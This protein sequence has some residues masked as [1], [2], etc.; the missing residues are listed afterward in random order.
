MINTFVRVGK[1]QQCYNEEESHFGLWCIMS[2]PLVLGFNMSNQ[3][4]MGRVWPVTTMAHP[5]RVFVL[6]FWLNSKTLIE[7]ML[8]P[9]QGDGALHGCLL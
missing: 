4:Q 7:C 2:S 5:L 3:D 1:N 9:M 6:F 8:S